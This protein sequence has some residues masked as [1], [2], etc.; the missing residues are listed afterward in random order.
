M[1]KKQNLAIGGEGTNGK[2]CQSSHEVHKDRLKKMRNMF[3]NLHA[4][5]PDIPLKANK[6]T[7]VDEAVNYIKNLQQ[8]LDKLEKEKQER[9]Q[10]TSTFGCESSMFATHQESSNNISNAMMETSN[11]ALSFPRQQP[12]TFHKTWA[13]SNVVL[14]ICGGEAQFTICAAHKAGLL[15]TIAFVL[16]KYKIGVVCLNISCIGNGKMDA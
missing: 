7:I 1:N 15:T 10:Y 6:C 16:E 5:L 12:T 9:L 3:T 14:N 8:T 4:L 2:C 11:S 13:S